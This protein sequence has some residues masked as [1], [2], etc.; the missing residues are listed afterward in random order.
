MKKKAYRITITYKTSVLATSYDTAWEIASRLAD[1]SGTQGLV[2]DVEVVRLGKKKLAA[3][4]KENNDCP[5]PQAGM[6]Y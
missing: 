1:G 3:L 5:I 4:K 6:F 2:M